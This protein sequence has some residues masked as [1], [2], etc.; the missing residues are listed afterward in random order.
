LQF[1]HRHAHFR[2]KILLQEHFQRQVHQVIRRKRECVHF[3]GPQELRRTARGRMR[4]WLGGRSR[5]GAAHSGSASARNAAR[6]RWRGQAASTAWPPKQHITA[7]ARGGGPAP[8]ATGRCAAPY[9]LASL[10][11]LLIALRPGTHRRRKAR[12][13]HPLSLRPSLSLGSRDL[14][15]Q[16]VTSKAPAARAARA[17]GPSATGRGV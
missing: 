8:A 16:A 4:A 14:G 15:T 6:C 13:R 1:L 7:H 2:G 11:G 3:H 9:L 17:A 10:E 5:A 12:A